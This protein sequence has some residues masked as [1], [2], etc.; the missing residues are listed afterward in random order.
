VREAVAVFDHLKGQ[1]I[2]AEADVDAAG[3]SA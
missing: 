3:M 1:L 2:V